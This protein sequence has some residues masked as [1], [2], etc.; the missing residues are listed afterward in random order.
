[1]NRANMHYS[2]QGMRNTIGQKYYL[3]RD[4]QVN[5]PQDILDTKVGY[6]SGG[7]L[8]PSWNNP[9]QMKLLMHSVWVLCS[10]KFHDGFPD[11]Q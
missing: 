6:Q 5:D 4:Q 9:M 7:M 1:M 8:H 2:T 10:R 11:P 3:Q